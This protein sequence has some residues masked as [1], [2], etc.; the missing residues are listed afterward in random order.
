MADIFIAYS[1]KDSVVA[2]RFKSVFETQGWSVFIDTGLQAGALFYQEIAHQLRIAR[3]VVVLWSD[4]AARSDFVI[5]EANEARQ[6]KKL[7]PARIED[8]PIP[9][10]FRG[11]QTPD[12]YDWDGG[13]DHA[14]LQRLLAALTARLSAR[15][16]DGETAGPSPAE[17][18]EVAVGDD[19]RDRLQDGSDAPAMVVLPS[20]RFW[21][22]EAD[23]HVPGMKVARPRHRVAFFEPFAV[24]RY[25]VT[26]VDYDRFCESAGR[27]R[28]R[29][30]W[31]RGNQPVVNVSWEDAVAY[32]EWLCQQTGRDYR[33]PSEAEWEYACR[34]GTQTPYYF[35]DKL[36]PQYANFDGEH[37]GTVAVDYFAPNPFGLCQMHGNVW[38]W[39]QDTWHGNYEGAPVDGSAW[40]GDQHGERVI[41]GG[42]WFYSAHGCRAAFR[43][44]ALHSEAEDGL[45]FR[46]CCGLAS[47]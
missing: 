43:S 1:R 18:L 5:D 2:N 9:Y 47:L 24:S 22:G 7:F 37:D 33:L 44:A 8:V 23:T 27:A 4:N 15:P 25:T 17:R 26:F 32:C 36:L 40:V 39:C 6:A 42:S 34:A 21:M 3:V 14:G 30:D 31:G 35:G 41:R 11:V 12:L 46:V 38:E 10:G 13:P 16:S 28:P 19:F 45:G 29:D 20:G